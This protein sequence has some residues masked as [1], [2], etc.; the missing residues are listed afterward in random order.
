MKKVKKMK[1]ANVI[2]LV[3]LFVF[4]VATG[5]FV[6]K[7]RD[8]L[9]PMYYV[10]TNQTY[11]L[12]QKKLDTDQ[13]ALDAIKE[14]G[15]EDV[16]PL[17]DDEAKKLN[18]GEISEEEAVDIILGRT[19]EDKQTGKNPSDV[20]SSLTTPE[21]DI[22]SSEEYKAKNE[23]I[24]QLIG[25]MYVLK[26][27]FSNDL[28]DIEKWVSE[29][30]VFYYKEYGGSE[31]I[32][33]SVKTKVGKQAYAKAIELEAECDSQVNNILSRITTLLKETGQSTK[34]VD[35]IREAYENEKML[36]KSYYM[37]KI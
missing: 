6:Y 17:T 37:S 11:K 20:P 24:A 10:I 4:I 9:L 8:T 3:I 21:P 27:K 26:A 19:E 5:I 33:S 29:K 28:A 12:E 30:Y 13:R 14:F 2:I 35:E 22:S 36:A 18:E 32:P 34:I 7:Q 23:E 16:R 25:K 1:K 15:I 31:N